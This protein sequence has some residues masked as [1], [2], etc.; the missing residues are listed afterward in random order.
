MTSRIAS[1]LFSHAVFMSVILIL[2]GAVKGFSLESDQKQRPVNRNHKN[3]AKETGPANLQKI[4]HYVRQ[5][6]DAAKR[7]GVS[8]SNFARSTIQKRFSGS[9]LRIDSAGYFYLHIG[10]KKIDEE[11]VGRLKALG[12]LVDHV[13]KKRRSVT[14]RVPFDVVE[15]VSMLECVGAIRGVMRPLNNVGAY[16]TAGNTVLRADSTRRLF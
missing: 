1:Y 12:I 9:M 14:A 15:R 4:D 2:S 13:D 5:A 10:M 6:I 3:L 8:R 16:T 11:T 7:E